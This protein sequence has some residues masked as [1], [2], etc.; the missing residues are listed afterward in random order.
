MKDSILREKSFTFAVDVIRLCKEM[1]TAHE[2]ILSNQLMKSATSIGALLR[3]A[4]YAESHADFKHK[5]MI[6]LKEANETGYIAA[7]CHL[8][9]ATCYL[10]PCFCYLTDITFACLKIPLAFST[11]N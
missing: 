2:Y 8:L 4:Q 1:S 10:L 6:A 5:F 7:N 3:E 11:R 9:L